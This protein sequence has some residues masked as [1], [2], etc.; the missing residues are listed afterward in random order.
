MPHSPGYALCREAN[1]TGK[2][3]P[4]KNAAEHH[5][6]VY[7]E[8]SKAEVT[9]S[10]LTRSCTLDSWWIIGVNRVTRVIQPLEDTGST[11]N[12]TYPRVIRLRH[13]S[14]SDYAHLPKS[15]GL[16][17]LDHVSLYLDHLNLIRF[18]LPIFATNTNLSTTTRRKNLNFS[19]I[20]VEI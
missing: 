11:W 12:N 2:R 7:I 20:H 14:I 16:I 4:P 1:E 10:Y 18:S 19:D 13:V 17:N 9:L 3:K 8:V 15:R 6:K 5:E